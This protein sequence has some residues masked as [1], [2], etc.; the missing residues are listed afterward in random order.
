MPNKLRS[1]A[2]KVVEVV[3]LATLAVAC[4]LAVVF[5]L[6]ICLAGIS[7]VVG[8]I[9]NAWNDATTLSTEERMQIERANAEWAKDPTNPAV[10]GKNCMDKGGT[11]VYSAWDGRVK[12]CQGVNNKNVNIEVNQ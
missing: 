4:I 3:T 1:R 2:F 10:V 11:P 8:G 6:N 12:E 9:G 5:V 7:W